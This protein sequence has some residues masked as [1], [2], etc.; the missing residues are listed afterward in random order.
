MNSKV[1][2]SS[3]R[4]TLMLFLCGFSVLLLFNYTGFAKSDFFTESMSAI[5]GLALIMLCFVPSIVIKNHTRLDFITF[6]KKTTPS[7]IIFVSSYYALYF[8]F[9]ATGALIRYTDMFSKSLNS[10][11]NKYVMAFLLLAV[12]VYAAHK[13]VNSISRTSIFIFIFFLIF[14]TLIVCGNIQNF[15]FKANFA[16]IRPEYNSF[17]RSISYYSSVAFIAVIFGFTSLNTSGYKLKHTITATA[18]ILVIALIFLFFIYF[19]LGSYGSQQP[20]QVFLLSKSSKLGAMGGIDSFYLSASTAGIFL[21]I[22]AVL[23]CMKNLSEDRCSTK[24]LL[25]FSVI[26]FVLFVCAQNYKSVRELLTN[27]YVI[28]IFNFISAVFIPAIYIFIFRRRLNV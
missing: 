14:L 25:L 24:I 11:T 21:I 19:V 18:A 6:A 10:E 16:P 3:A 28:S 1:S 23:A 15:D 7:A 5:F 2:F 22:S 8:V 9:L 4:L 27:Y 13:G 20:Y 17:M 12:C 26:I